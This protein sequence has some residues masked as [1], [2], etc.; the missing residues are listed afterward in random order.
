MNTLFVN[1]ENKVKN[2]KTIG[3]GFG[4]KKVSDSK[5]ILY[6]YGIPDREVEFKTSLDK[7]IFAAELVLRRGVVKKHLAEVLD[8]SRKTIDVWVDVYQK[9]GCKA[10]VNSSKQ[11]VGR[12]KK[13]EIVRPRGNKF[14]QYQQDN[15][16]ERRKIEEINKLQINIDYS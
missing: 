5:F 4:L 9:G 7:R 1:D 14:D 3:N 16:D 13:E 10:L 12:K 11:G 15:M 6:R 8:V 2:M